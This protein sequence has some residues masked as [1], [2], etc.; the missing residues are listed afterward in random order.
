MRFLILKETPLS[1]AMSILGIISLLMAIIFFQSALWPAF[2]VAVVLTILF[3]AIAFK[4]QNKAM[5]R[6]LETEREYAEK[7]FTLSADEDK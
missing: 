5:A 1:L 7:K 6:R 4:S 2:G 3:Y